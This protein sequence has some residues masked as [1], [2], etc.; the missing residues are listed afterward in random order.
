MTDDANDEHLIGYRK[1]RDRAVR[2][3]PVMLGTSAVRCAHIVDTIAI[4]YNINIYI[5]EQDDTN[6]DRNYAI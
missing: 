6:H 3:R 1:T 4:L 2:A 5:T